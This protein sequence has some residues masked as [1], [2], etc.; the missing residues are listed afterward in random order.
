[1]IRHSNVEVVDAFLQR[2]SAMSGLNTD[3][4]TIWSYAWPMAWW[5][6]D[7]VVM[8]PLPRGASQ[9]TRRHWLLLRRLNG[10]H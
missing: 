1:M 8:N 5:K 4:E 9:T 2:R 10:A 3:G 7:E 6:D